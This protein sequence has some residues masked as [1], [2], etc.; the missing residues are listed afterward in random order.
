MSIAR[1]ILFNTGS[2]I[3]AK[4]ILAIV[5]FA[6]VKV[7]TNY[8]SLEG[9]G[10]YTAV[11]DFIALF[12]IASDLGLYTIAVR[13]MSRDETKIEYILGNVLSI[14]T[15]LAVLIMVIAVATSFIYARPDTDI[16]FPLAAGITATATVFALL[17]GTISTVLQVHYKMQY[18]AL[19]SVIG[20]LVALG[21]MIFVIYFW[22]PTDTVSGF[23]QLLSAGII[24]NIALFGVTYYYTRKLA[25]IRYR[26]DWIFIKDVI[27]KSLPYGLA[28]ILNTLY[29]RIGSIM[30]YLMIGPEASAIYGVPLKI[31]E[32]I[33]ILPLYFMNSV[34][35]TLSKA[36]K[37]NSDRYKKIIQYSFDALVMGGI[38]MA[39]GTSVISWQVIGLLSDEKYLSRLNEG[40]YGSD[41]V[42]QIIIFALAFSFIN[43]LFGFILVAI[44]KQSKMLYVNGGGVIFAVAANYILLPIMGAPGAAITDILVELFVVIGAYA[45]AK[46]YL[47]FKIKLGNTAKIVFSGIVMGVAL[48]YLKEPTFHFMNLN[49]KNIILLVP[50]GG[51]IYVSLLFALKVI[52]PEMIA[53][54]KKEKPSV[55]PAPPP[56]N[57]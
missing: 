54:L 42:L 19:A 16:L 44:N 13:E 9:Y 45:F 40:F 57:L 7:I 23:Y 48:Y 1:K 14:R 15:I 52:T 3:L 10:N 21:Y 5:G 47:E 22:S 27:L 34:L 41:I 39:I 20:K 11:Y 46:H 36:V 30:V 37:E 31:L 28:L 32:S 4:A 29:F 51:M 35:P 53:M 56:D 49:N 17:T 8:L 43:T 6:T 25:K 26:F 38:P 18:N 24:G 12:G 2:Q 50:I 55:S 33:A